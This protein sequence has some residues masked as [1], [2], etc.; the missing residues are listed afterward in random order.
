MFEGKIDIITKTIGICRTPFI[1]LQIFVLLIQQWV[2]ICFYNLF[3][4]NVS[5]SE[6]SFTKG[7]NYSCVLFK[8]TIPNWL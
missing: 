8:K 5:K 2:C 4:Y 1:F 7:L 6:G 3:E